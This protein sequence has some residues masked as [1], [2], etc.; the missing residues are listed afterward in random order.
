VKT[1]ALE[2]GSTKKAS[3][4]ADEL[5]KE[6]VKIEREHEASLLKQ[7]AALQ[8]QQLDLK[9]RQIQFAF[10]PDDMLDKNLEKI[11]KQQKNILHQ[12]EHDLHK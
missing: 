10:I 3:K 6:Q 12:L 2:K 4:V 8:R 7:I 9:L 11:L 5:I 1:A